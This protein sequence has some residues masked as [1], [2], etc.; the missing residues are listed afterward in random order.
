[1]SSQARAV[2]D[3]TRVQSID[4]LRGTVMVIM[5]L[6]HVRAYF[7]AA[8]LV[9]SPTDLERTSVILFFTR[10]ITHY[11]APV[12]VFLAGVSA[13][14]YG[15][16]RGRQVLSTFLWTRGLWLVFTELFILSF[17]RTF[18]PA[19]PYFNLQVIWAIGLCM[20]ILS[21]LIRLETRSILLI[22]LALIV[23]HN[24]LDTVHVAGDGIPAFL[25]AVLHET[26]RFTFGPFLVNV[27]YPLL[28][29][30]G[31]MAVGY[32][33][34]GLYTSEQPAR[35]RRILLLTG[36]VVTLVFI[37]LRFLNGYGDPAPWSAQRSIAFEILSFLNL[38]KYPP[39]LLY[40]AMTLGPAL[41]FLACTERVPREVAAPIALFG[42]VA[43]FYYLAHILLIHSAA[44]LA[45]PLGGYSMSDMVLSSSLID[46]AALKGYGYGLP[47]VYLVWIG[48][49]LVL[50]PCCR[51]FDRYK[52]AHQSTH[53]WLSYL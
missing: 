53:W 23:G 38:T 13:H 50:Y 6:D 41:V 4:L 25:W 16:R 14:I 42:R 1:M 18:N 24:L 36:L 9:H 27:Q 15:A 10:W 49:V 47:T 21:V 46:T 30:I 34:G 8:A 48:L 3:V 52:R 5:A 32:W 17:F 29:W 19:F 31:T 20:L 28:P 43:M 12:F 2:P 7:H 40:L 44:T 39:S 22:G 45:A 26:R 33:F 51:W 35:R 11:C 37:D